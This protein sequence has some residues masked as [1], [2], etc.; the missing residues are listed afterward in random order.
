MD[1]NSNG[2]SHSYTRK[3]IFPCFIHRQHFRSD[4]IWKCSI[5]LFAHILSILVNSANFLK[6]TKKNHNSHDVLHN[7]HTLQMNAKHICQQQPKICIFFL[8]IIRM[9]SVC[10]GIQ[11]AIILFSFFGFCLTPHKKIRNQFQCLLKS[12]AYIV[13]NAAGRV[14]NLPFH[15]K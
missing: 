12:R 8:S 5:Q 3:R 9:H 7:T 10:S 2:S 4:V 11:I 15:E 13:Q 1:V 14:H 6:V